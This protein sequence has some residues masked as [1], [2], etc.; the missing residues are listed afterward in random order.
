MNDSMRERTTCN[1]CGLG[2]TI[3]DRCPSCGNLSLYIASD[4]RVT[5]SLSR[6][7][8][9]ALWWKYHDH[10]SQLKSASQVVPQDAKVDLMWVRKFVEYA[11]Y[12]LQPG[13]Q[14]VGDQFPRQDAADKAIAK[15]DGI[16]ATLAGEANK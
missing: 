5:C 13:E 3:S 10:R 14:Q 7:G 15:L 4:G 12:E 9:K 8:G 11:R 6:C 2:T 1:V 16:I